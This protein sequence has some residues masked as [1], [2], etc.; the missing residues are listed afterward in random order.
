MNFARSLPDVGARDEAL[1]GVVRRSVDVEDLLQAYEEIENPDIKSRAARRLYGVMLQ[2]DPE[3]AEAFRATEGIE[4]AQA[5]AA[6]VQNGMV[7]E[8]TTR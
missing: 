5:G 2:S 3:R 6:R 4:S 7:L 8:R 1:A